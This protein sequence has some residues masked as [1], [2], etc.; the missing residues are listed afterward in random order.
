MNIFA[1]EQNND[2]TIDWVGSATSQDNL[3]VVKMALESC[4][5]LCTNLNHLYGEKVS[6]YR[7]CHLNH[8]S[9]KW[10]RESSANFLLLVKHTEA[11]LAEYTLR[12]GK[13]H[14]CQGVLEQ[15]MELYDKSLFD[16]H[17]VTP[18]PLCMPDE[19]KSDNIVESYRRFYASKPK[20]RYPSAKIPSWF[21]DY[22]GDLAYEII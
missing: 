19:Y 10:A 9:T 2:G 15:V 7:S 5:M 17:T 12:F 18:L 22:R 20:V 16:L 6:P 1:I 8:P 21:K 4:Q 11:L 14:K 13:I 3:R